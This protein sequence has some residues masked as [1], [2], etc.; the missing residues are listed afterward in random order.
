M[1]VE[2]HLGVCASCADLDDANDLAAGALR[3]TQFPPLGS[4][5]RA[6]AR[7]DPVPTMRR[8]IG[9]AA[10][11]AAVVAAAAV[12][13]GLLP[14]QTDAQ[15][16]TDR[17]LR[18]PPTAAPVA[19]RTPAPQDTAPPPGPPTAGTSDASTD[20]D[21]PTAPTA[22]AGPTSEDPAEA[23]EGPP[24][25]FVPHVFDDLRDRV[26]EIDLDAAADDP[27]FS[28][29]VRRV[30]SAGTAGAC[31]LAELL[32]PK[33][34]EIARRAARIAA[35][36]RSAQFV[37]PLGRLL[38]DEDLAPDAAAALAAIDAPAAAEMLVAAPPGPAR[39][40]ALDVLSRSRSPRAFDALAARLRAD[41]LES[42][43]TA[44][45]LEAAVALDPRRAARLLLD[46]AATSQDAE[47]VETLLRA[48]SDVLVPAILP[49]ASRNDVLVASAAVRAL[50]QA[51]DPSAVPTLRSAGARAA[52]ARPAADA[53]LRIGTDEALAAAFDVAAAPGAPRE[54]L[55][56]F[57]G[58]TAAT[59]RLVRELSDPR[60]T[61]RLAA[62]QALGWTRAEAAVP[63]LATAAAETSQRAAVVE[64]LGR[65][66]G[67]EAAALLAEWVRP[68]GTDVSLV[69]AL[70]ATGSEAAVPA[71]RKISRE[72]ALG[73][74]VAQALGEIPQ[75]ES[76]HALADLLAEA[77]TARAAAESLAGLPAGVVVPALV[78]RLENPEAAARAHRALVLVA[79]SDLGQNPRAWRAW[80]ESRRTRTPERRR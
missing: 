51:G 47:T 33:D 37:A 17:T 48:H 74:P 14:R 77:R 9:I 54:S 11:A 58:C 78:D 22:V 24:A 45:L 65:I 16:N 67:D 80:W 36:V 68:R 70:G 55:S 42:D 25:P 66:G 1:V 26:A 44:A 57:E 2:A 69:V 46:V 73:V 19:D 20:D 34:P 35:E 72:P 50:G 40:A 23:P 5:D 41:A 10:A 79:G 71:L 13:T 61:R 53:L 76:V 64:A 12:A 15:P 49:L 43:D 21:V 29:T 7:L 30:H 56:V 3:A 62:I 59:P 60:A 6:L 63:A 8:R 28:A 75:K 52:L 39:R 18:T 32:D 4:A 27:A 31:A 38:E